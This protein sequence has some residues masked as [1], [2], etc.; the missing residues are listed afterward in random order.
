MSPQICLLPQAISELFVQITKSGEITLADRY[1]LFAATFS[2]TLT[3]DERRA[4]NRLLR[5][6]SLGRL[7][8]V[9]KLSAIA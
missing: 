2:Q 5:A 8:V 4:L 7:K 3:E 6:A 1:G 9:D